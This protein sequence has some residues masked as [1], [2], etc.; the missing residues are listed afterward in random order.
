M[1]HA[2]TV[3]NA[4]PGS[5]QCLTVTIETKIQPIE[6]DGITVTIHQ[7]KVFHKAREGGRD[8]QQCNILPCLGIVGE[9]LAQFARMPMDIGQ[10]R[11]RVGQRLQL[12]D[13]F[14]GEQHAWVGGNFTQ[15]Q[16]IKF[17]TCH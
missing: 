15:R 2:A 16:E 14:G 10:Q 12:P 13:A 7:G 3:S 17:R 11:F 6:C 9:R 1:D 8:R 4:R 5:F